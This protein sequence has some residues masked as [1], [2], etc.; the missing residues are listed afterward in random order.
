[1]NYKKL[2]FAFFIASI[3]LSTLFY[4]IT[5]DLLLSIVNLSLYLIIFSYSILFK[6]KKYENELIKDNECIN[7]INKFIISLSFNPSLSTAFD[8]CRPLLTNKRT[9]KIKNIES[10][11]EKLS[12]LEKEYNL[13]LYDM[14]LKFVN[15]YIEN[16]GNILDSSL[17]FLSETR[18][19]QSLENNLKKLKFSGFLSF[20]FMWIF[21][22]L[23]LIIARFSLN[24]FYYTFISNNKYTYV[25]LIGFLFFSISVLIY[26]IQ[27]F[28]IKFIKKGKYNEK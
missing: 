28:N 23:I 4:F 13:Q 12:F 10:I 1:M 26:F 27:E 16:G 18:R 20:I 3:I 11:N 9:N 15:Q 5:Q 8:N 17:S 14:F 24:S 19:I 25:I 2:F 6:Y 22:F 7:F 21:S